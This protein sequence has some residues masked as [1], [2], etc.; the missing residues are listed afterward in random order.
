MK[1]NL[2]GEDIIKERNKKL[3]NTKTKQLK[4]KY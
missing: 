2:K 3:S 4:K 1:N